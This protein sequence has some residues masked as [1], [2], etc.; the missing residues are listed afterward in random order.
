MWSRERHSSS[1]FI[2]HRCGNTFTFIWQLRITICYSVLNAIQN[3]HSEVF[4]FI[5][6]LRL[7]L[8]NISEKDKYLLLSISLWHLICCSHT[9]GAEC[10]CVP[11]LRS[12]TAPLLSQC[13]LHTLPLSSHLCIMASSQSTCSIS[14]N[15]TCLQATQDRHIC[16]WFAMGSASFSISAHMVDVS[17]ALPHRELDARS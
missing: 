8:Q 7:I 4:F 9:C 2:A 15:E 12:H 6:A 11:L 16:L 13:R 3:D 14:H 17:A 10:F 5:E 1:C